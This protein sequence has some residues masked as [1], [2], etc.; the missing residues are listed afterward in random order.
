MVAVKA[1]Y[2]GQAFIPVSP[3]SAVK[4]QAAI[5]T[6]LDTP[7]SAKREGSP[8]D[9]RVALTNIQR[10]TGK[11]MSESRST[12]P[13][14]TSNT[15]ADVTRMLD[16]RRELNG[17][18]EASGLK[19]KITV[20]DFVLAATVKA[21]VAHPRVNSVLDG[22]ELIYKGSVNLGLAV[23]TERGLLVPVIAAAQDLGL[24]GISG[25]AA[26]LAVK[27]REGKLSPDEMSGGT[28]TVSN[29]GMY[30]VTSFTPIINLP[31]AAIL[32]VCSIE[33]QLKLEGEK[34]VNRKKMGLSLAYDHRIVDGADSALFLKTIRDLLEAPLLLLA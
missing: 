6:I 27:A 30:G 4:N 9:T 31:E 14:V 18:L 8:L 12:I 17:D 10:I 24:L 34:V 28:F 32:G 23:A 20:N 19:A 15:L 7:P 5:I 3:V 1:Y 29:I 13:E 25:A 2:D 21:L 11:R 26:A 16:I 22:N 33:D